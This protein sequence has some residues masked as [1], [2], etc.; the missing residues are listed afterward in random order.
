[1][2]LFLGA[3]EDREAAAEKSTEVTWKKKRRVTEDKKN[4]ALILEH[5]NAVVFRLHR[6]KFLC[7]YC[8]KICLNVS[9]VVRDHSAIH[10]KL[11]LFGERPAV[12]NTFPLRIDITRLACNLCG[13]KIQNI[14]KLKTH[15]ADEHSK[16]INQNFSDGVVPF[17]LTDKEYKCVHCSKV[18]ERYLTLFNHMNKHYQTHVCPSCGKGFSGRNKL[19]R[20]VTTHAYGQFNCPK[21]DSLFPNRA[22][23]NSHLSIAHGRKDRYRCPIC[24]EYFADYRPRVRHLEKVHGLKSG[25]KK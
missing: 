17:V 2:F 20:H 14:D 8:P 21:C 13:T 12:R 5:S 15:L 3:I 1:M 6:G 16:F 11:D 4:A 19:R 24:D 22:K 9:Y 10:E 7:A 25:V 23:M 18:F